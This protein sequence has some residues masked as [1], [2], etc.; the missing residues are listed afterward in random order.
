MPAMNAVSFTDPY[1]AEQAEIERRRR[2]AEMLQA[3]GAQGLGGTEVVGGWAIP[4]SPLEG[5]GKAGQQVSG[6]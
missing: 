5:L 6:A 4:R 3:Q 1:A 2:M